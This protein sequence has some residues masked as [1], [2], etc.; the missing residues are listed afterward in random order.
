MQN[1]GEGLGESS[2]YYTILENSKVLQY[3]I[4]S[5]RVDNSFLIKTFWCIDSADSARRFEILLAGEPVLRIPT[6]EEHRELL[7]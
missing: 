7:M 3:L 4:V 6:V 5:A 1:Q 2:S